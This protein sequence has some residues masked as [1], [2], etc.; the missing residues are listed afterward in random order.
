MEE[1]Y[2]QKLGGA[3]N[4]TGARWRGVAVLLIYGKPCNSWGAHN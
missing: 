2:S 4:G 3:K 1:M